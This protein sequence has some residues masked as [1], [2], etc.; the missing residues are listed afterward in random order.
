MSRWWGERLRIGLAPDRVELALRKGL[1]RAPELQ[2]IECARDPG[3]PPWQAALAALEDTL[4]GLA[5]RGGVAVV[6]SNHLVRYQ[7]LA[8]QAEINGAR[9][10]EQLARLQFE[11]VFGEAAAG[12]TV[13]CSVGGWGQASLACAVDTALVEALTALLARR[14]LRLTSL[15][16]LLMAA[17]NGHRRALPRNAALAIVEPGRL[18]LGLL[19]NAHWV[20]VISRRLQGDAAAAAEQELAALAPEAE[21]ARFDVLRIGAAQWPEGGSRP[22]QLLGPADATPL[23]LCG[24]T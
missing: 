23:A 4:T 24:A 6:L 14:G 15:Q 13:R 20:E 12:W 2:A 7:V 11:R 8:W 3:Q 1:G 5:L 22:S 17:Y 19:R 21:P 16:P 9:E 18:C 10:L